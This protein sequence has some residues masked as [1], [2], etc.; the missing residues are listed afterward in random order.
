MPSE[1]FG[2]R[3]PSRSHGYARRRPWVAAAL[4]ATLWGAP[5][6]SGP[7]V[8]DDGWEKASPGYPW[9]F[10]RDHWAHHSYRNEW[11]YFTGH[12]K[13][14][15]EPKAR[16]GYQFTIFRIGASPR[17][18][19][20]DS[21]WSTRS[22]IMGH[23]A[24]S[25]L[26]EGR[27]YFSELVFRAAPFLAAFGAPPDPLIAWSRGPAGTSERWELH[28]NGRGFDLR[29]VD[30][31]QGLEMELSTR[32][33]KP[34]VFQGPDG[35]SRKSASGQGASLYYSMTQLE[36]SGRLRLG[37]REF[38]VEG[39]SWMDKEFSSNV[40]EEHQAGWD[41]FS[42]QLDDGREL[43]LF[44]L[45]D[46]QGKVDFGSATLVSESGE[47][48]Y[49]SRGDWVLEVVRRWKSPETG[50][51][52]PVEWNL[53]LPRQGLRLRLRTL[54]DNQENRSRIIPSLFYWEGA[55]ELLDETGRRLGQG[56]A[57]LTGYGDG[58]RPPI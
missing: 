36:T 2:K 16:F 31:L 49:L 13:S 29:A 52:Y 51:L 57:E 54:L 30:S 19:D 34:L 42:L 22:M 47:C 26:E 10:P 23:A 45:R 5:G 3:N 24:I 40:L 39:M 27:H 28:W 43:M 33:L 46:R 7:P 56:Y 25:D 17:P 32:A 53:E 15:G 55:L 4:L 44:E 37:G 18:V 6:A 48:A 8:G 35:Y 1:R 21:N 58:S 41:W 12:L 50:A 20:L 11:W 14:A 9:S 38:E